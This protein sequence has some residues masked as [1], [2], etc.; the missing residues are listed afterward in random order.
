MLPIADL[1]TE[2][3]L[4]F[5]MT[6]P[7]VAVMSC[8][9]NAASKLALTCSA[10]GG[11]QKSSLGLILVSVKE[12]TC[13]NSRYPNRNCHGCT[14]FNVIHVEERDWTC[15]IVPE[16]SKLKVTERRKKIVR[17]SP[18]MYFYFT[19]VG[20]QESFQMFVDSPF[21]ILQPVSSSNKLRALQML[22]QV[23]EG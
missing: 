11:L 18:H 23:K 12:L 6:I 9:E 1:S 4:S 22:H 15:S 17:N 2:S 3:D 21:P 10:L 14:Y 5:L 13:S 7:T 20:S 16:S 8:C 19:W